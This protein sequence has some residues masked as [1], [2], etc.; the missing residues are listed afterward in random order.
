MDATGNSREKREKETIW[1]Q[2]RIMMDSKVNNYNGQRI[3][4][5]RQQTDKSNKQNPNIQFLT[6]YTSMKNR[7]NLRVNKGFYQDLISKEISV[8]TFQTFFQNWGPEIS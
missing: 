2:T 7:H 3:E 1:R 8:G 6:V 5:P 4:N